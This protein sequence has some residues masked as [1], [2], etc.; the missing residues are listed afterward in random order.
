MLEDFKITILFLADPEVNLQTLVNMIL[1]AATSNWS[2]GIERHL[3]W[4]LLAIS[5][6]YEY[7]PAWR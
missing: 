3:Q 4:N 1:Q 2:M 6:V 7:I 5:V